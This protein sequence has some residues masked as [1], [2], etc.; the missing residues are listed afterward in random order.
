MNMDIETIAIAVLS[1]LGISG[2]VGIYLQHLWAQKRETESRIQ[3]ENRK[4][5][6]STL[7]WMRILLNPESVAHYN[8][9]KLDPN[10]LKLNP[11]ELKEHA[12]KMLVT[13]YYES[14]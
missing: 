1:S 14:V 2:L 3:S 5:Y 11:T 6:E 9:G 7:V 10:I 12:R 4:T 8:V 13:F